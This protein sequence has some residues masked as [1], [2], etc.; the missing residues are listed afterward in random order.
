[1]IPASTNFANANVGLVKTPWH[2][3]QI[4]GYSPI[5]T[6]GHTGIGGQFPW[7]S[8]MGALSQKVNDLEGTST[9]S[10]M[11]IEIIDKNQQITSA[12]PTF[13]FE[14]KQ[15]TVLTGFPTINYPGDFLTVATMII[16]K[17][18]ATADNTVW[19]FTLKDASRLSK[20][21]V[22]YTV[23][24]DGY[25]TS[26]D[27][28][29]TLVANPMDLLSDVL[30]NQLGFPAAQVNTS[31]IAR[32]KAGLFSGM[33]MKFRLTTA[34]EAKSWLDREIFKA[35]GGYSFANYLGQVTPVYFI[36]NKAPVS[37]LTLTD[38]NL[39]KLP[40]PAQA[41]IVNFVTYR[42]DASEKRRSSSSSARS[43]FNS[44]LTDVYGTSVTVFSKLQGQQVIESRGL[45]SESGGWRYA[46]LLVNTLFLRYGSK[47]MLL[48]VDAFWTSVIVEPGDFVRVTHSLIPNRTTGTLGLTNRLFEV[49]EVKKD[50]DKGVVSLRLLDMAWL[51]ALAAAQVAPDGEP[52]W[53]LAT[54]PERLQ[55]MFISNSAGVHSDGSAGQGIF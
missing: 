45:E 24:D 5:F 28:P 38:H 3:L 22:V 54:A 7:I 47:P 46:R 33:Q 36:P 35:L 12:F 14:G 19:V 40:T 2:I 1:M 26:S 53:T 32:L 18:E 34:P 16:D 44:E 39:A 4:A 17:V 37:D 49:L 48:D 52:A 10:D 50:F 20:G 31:E 21:T 13:T 41:E 9:L 23:A 51:D 15:A 25:L 8:K 11:T 42:L 30:L 29:K 6:F 43:G 55:Y 27:H